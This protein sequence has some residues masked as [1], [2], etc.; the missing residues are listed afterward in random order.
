M[1][2]WTNLP[3]PPA[4]RVEAGTMGGFEK[5]IRL[6]KKGSWGEGVRG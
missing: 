2:L 5:L 4:R 1:G 6:K 3:L